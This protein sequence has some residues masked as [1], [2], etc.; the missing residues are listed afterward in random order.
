VP[1]GVK[2]GPII[3]ISRQRSG[4]GVLAHVVLLAVVLV[5]VAWAVAW[6]FLFNVS[7]SRAWVLA[8][9]YWGVLAG[10][11]V[12]L[13]TYWHGHRKRYTAAMSEGGA[14]IWRCDHQHKT[15]AEAR[16]CTAEHDP[17][18]P[19]A[20]ASQPVGRH[21]LRGPSATTVE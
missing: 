15:L 18:S 3:Y 19:A 7:G 16:A 17:F 4:P 12:F 8:G 14:V 11:A 5:A 1:W 20:A 6:P 21:F 9:A 2:V 13:V 10:L